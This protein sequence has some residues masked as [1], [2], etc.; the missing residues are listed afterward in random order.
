LLT[1][2][3]AFDPHVRGL[4]FPAATYVGLALQMGVIGVVLTAISSRLQRPMRM[5]TAG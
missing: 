2:V 5:A 4:G 1:P 3:Q